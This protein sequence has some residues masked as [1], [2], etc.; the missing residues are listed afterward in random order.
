MAGIC[1][2]LAVI[3]EHAQDG[4]FDWAG[5][6]DA[7]LVVVECLR[8][9]GAV[10]SIDVEEMFDGAFNEQVEQL[11]GLLRESVL[12]PTLRNDNTMTYLFESHVVSEVCSF[13]S[14]LA[15][16]NKEP[17]SI[18][19]SLLVT[20]LEP[21]NLLQTG[22][23]NFANTQADVIIS[24]CLAGVGSVF[25]QGSATDALVKAV[26]QL[27][28]N[29]IVAPNAE[30]PSKILDAAKSLLGE[31]LKQKCVSLK[32][33]QLIACDLASTENW[34]GWS[35]I[36]TLN[37]G[38]AIAKSLEV[39]QET[40]RSSDPAESQVAA[41]A[42]IRSVAQKASG[43]VVGRLLRT[44]G[45]DVVVVLYQYGTM[46]FPDLAP[47]HRTAGCADAMKI[48]L[49]AYRQILAED[50]DEQV[51][52]FLSVIFETFLAVLRYN[53]L[54][55]HPTHEPFGDPALGRIC[56]QAVLHVARTS[57]MQSKKC[58]ATLSEHDRTLLEFAVRAEMSGYAKAQQQAPAKKKLS[59]KGFQ[60]I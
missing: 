21:L 30:L 47:T 53:G 34:E 33:Q 24:A 5:G 29:S 27:I 36:S 59:L 4:G 40:L 54:P 41:L 52:N 16:C 7:S 9:M 48:I 10:V 42:A 50:N 57:P 35:V 32:E 44:V 19:S 8:G 60:S 38:K 3:T 2:G 58:M 45:A 17:F 15:V 51:S 18:D 28:L 12:I 6:I 56:A 49:I 46:K 20:L 14:H 55:N 23:I 39:V 26:L 22:Q 37:D 13:I 31:C 43:P 25:R 1:D 11:I